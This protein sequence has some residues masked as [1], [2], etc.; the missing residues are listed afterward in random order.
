VTSEERKIIDQLDALVFKK[1]AL[2]EIESLAKHLFKQ[3]QTKPAA[4]FMRAEL[5]L[6]LFGKTL[7]H[8]IKSSNVYVIRPSV[9][10]GLERHP[11]SH[12]RSLALAGEGV[13]ELGTGSPQ[14]HSIGN[15]ATATAAERWVSIPPN[16]WHQAVAAGNYWTVVTFHTALDQEII[17]ERQ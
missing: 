15:R 17:N 11:N 14:S 16:I 4:A 7:P 3:L 9:S 10:S 1:E 2:Q 13:F 6:A 5:P 12:Q 8:D